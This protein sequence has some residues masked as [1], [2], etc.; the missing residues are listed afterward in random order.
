MTSEDSFS[1]WGE[2][3][4]GAKR[5]LNLVNQFLWFQHLVVLLFEFFSGF[6]TPK[7]REFFD[8][9]YQFTP[10]RD[11]PVQWQ[12]EY[13]V[14]SERT[15]NW[16]LSLQDA[17]WVTFALGSSL[18]WSLALGMRGRCQNS[19]EKRSILPLPKPNGPDHGLFKPTGQVDGVAASF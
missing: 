11:W 6:W 17:W 18:H 14:R 1:S 10:K 2:V 8:R 3:A 16:N 4:E 13:C 9:V 7:M 15:E 5:N 12:V 19:P